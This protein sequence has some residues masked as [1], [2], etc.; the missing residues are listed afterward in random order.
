[1][2]PFV[3]FCKV[4]YFRLLQK[5]YYKNKSLILVFNAV[6]LLY[7]DCFQYLISFSILCFLDLC[8]TFGSCEC[9]MTNICI[10][11]LTVCKKLHD[12]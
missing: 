10:K 5:G 7:L 6:F 11:G 12:D 8:L 2:R 9:A 1:M 4:G 3:L